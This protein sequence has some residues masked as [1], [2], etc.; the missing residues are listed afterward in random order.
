MSSRLYTGWYWEWRSQRFLR[1][2]GMRPITR[3]HRCRGGEVDLI[4]WDGETVVFVE[5][6]Y[7][8]S[9]D[10]GTAAETVHH[11]K[12]RRI[13]VAARHFLAQNPRFASRPCRFDVIAIDGIFQPT[14]QWIK[15]AFDLT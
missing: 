11:H 3:N 15:G 14:P 5:V 12:Q 2:Q 4:M 6:R 9:A 13:G 8:S 1:L 7:R 10:R